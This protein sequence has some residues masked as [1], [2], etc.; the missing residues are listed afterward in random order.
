MGRPDVSKPING[1]EFTFFRR[2]LREHPNVWTKV[3]CPERLTVNGP[4]ALGGEREAYRD[5]V[6]FARALVEE[7]PDRVLWGTDFPHPNLK[8][9]M[10][11]AHST[12]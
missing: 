12:V 3:S 6:L 8:S 10:P 9:H 7:F 5:V 2:F 4:P 11:F 1:P